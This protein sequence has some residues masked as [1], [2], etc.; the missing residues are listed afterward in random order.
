MFIWS[1]TGYH[2]FGCYKTMSEAE[3]FDQAIFLGRRARMQRVSRLLT[4]Q[5]I[6]TIAGV[7]PEDVELFENNQYLNPITKHKIA[8]TFELI[9]EA[10]NKPK[11]LP[12]LSY[13][14]HFSH[15]RKLIF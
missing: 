14:P 10:N 13:F 9:T 12:K 4:Q 2:C 8:R 7:Y 1:I 6:A 11:M 15:E 3:S 5:E